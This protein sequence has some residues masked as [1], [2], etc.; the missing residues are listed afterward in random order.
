MWRSMIYWILDLLSHEHI[1]FLQP[2]ASRVDFRMHGYSAILRIGH[3]RGGAQC[4]VHALTNAT[5]RSL[6]RIASPCINFTP[7]PTIANIAQT[8]PTSIEASS[9][10]FVVSTMESPEL[11]VLALPY[12]PCQPRRK[13]EGS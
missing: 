3:L 5:V 12:D 2:S 11:P 13:D 1:S 8:L 10:S 4:I 9:P 7:L 6:P